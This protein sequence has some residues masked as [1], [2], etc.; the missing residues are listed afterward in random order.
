M[1]RNKKVYLVLGSSCSGKS[2]YVRSNSDSGDLIFDFDNIHKAI[3][4]NPSH[5][6]IKNIKDYVFE[7]RKTIYNK[8]KEDDNIRAWIINSTPYKENRQKIVDE[9]GAE[10]IYLKR[11]KEKC[12]EIAKNE[13][14][15]E[16][17]EYIENYHQNFQDFDDTENVKIID[18]DNETLNKRNNLNT[19]GLERRNFINSEI[20][21]ANS[22]SREVVGYASV[23][24]DSEGNPA[25]SE[26]LGGFREKIDPNSF[27]T[28]LDD[29]VKALFNH[30]PD[31]ILA[32]KA[33]SLKLSVDERG[34]KYSFT[35]PEGLS[36]GN[37]LLV[38]LENGNVTQSSFGF[39]V[40]EDSWDEDEDGNTIRTIIKVGRLLDV[41]PVVYPAY[42]D[43]T[44]AKRNFLN[45]R[46][47]REKQENK[48]QEKYQI[49]RELLD[50]K[51]KLLKL[52]NSY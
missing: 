10:I 42:P 30:N 27:D 15:E 29:D 12:L 35:I 19:E 41:S 22:E 6:H 20:R 48:K 8:L 50:K 4:N 9:L 11:S 3:S 5:R 45:Y 51:I 24:T 49:K 1:E 21:I 18:M 33:N 2:T 25:L 40:E 17:L 14:P 39:I 46:T 23:F 7:I 34:L 32:S 38:N 43:S 44:V 37:D 52:K 13:R 16:W 28:V 26:N 36:Y 47:E 31:L